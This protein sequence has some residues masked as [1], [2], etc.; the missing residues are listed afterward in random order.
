MAAQIPDLNVKIYE[1]L[2]G[3]LLF[4]NFSPNQETLFRAKSALSGADVGDFYLINSD[5]IN[6]D[7][8]TMFSVKDYSILQTGFL[9]DA[10]DSF[11]VKIALSNASEQPAS[12]ILRIFNDL[13]KFR[14]PFIVKAGNSGLV[15]NFFATSPDSF[16][17]KFFLFVFCISTL[18]LLYILKK[19]GYYDTD[20]WF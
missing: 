2:S 12:F 14:G 16:V 10:G 3:D 8:Y 11:K 13:R 4:Y 20:T 17:L 7:K 9:V 18:V 19:R 1:L 6:Y 15:F 5:L